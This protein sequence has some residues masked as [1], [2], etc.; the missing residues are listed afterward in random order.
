[1]N[2]CSIILCESLNIA[3]LNPAYIIFYNHGLLISYFNQLWQYKKKSNVK[4]IGSVV[5]VQIG[6]SRLLPV[7]WMSPESVMY[8]RFTLE[9]DVWSYGVVLWEIYSLGKQPYYGQSNEEVTWFLQRVC[10]SHLSLH[11]QSQAHR[12]TCR[13]VWN[14]TGLHCH[15]VWHLTSVHINNSLL[16]LLQHLTSFTQLRKCIF[17][18]LH[19]AAYLF[20]S[21][22]FV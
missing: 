7:R 1:M 22:E 10:D 16:H 3:K 8:G 4:V 5:L 17:V 14:W 20:E 18:G 12:L 2:L 9:S 13:C 6:G 15:R 21:Y 19:G 11:K